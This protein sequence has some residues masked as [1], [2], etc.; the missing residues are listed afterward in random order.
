[1]DKKDYKVNDYE[2]YYGIFARRNAEE[3]M[4]TVQI[5]GWNIDSAGMTSVMFFPRLCQPV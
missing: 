5:I 3:T 2:I 1:M 4:L